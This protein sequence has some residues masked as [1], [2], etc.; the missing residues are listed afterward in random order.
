MGLVPTL[1]FVS[2]V[3]WSFVLGPIGALLA[4]PLTLFAKALL[5]DADP[6]AQWVRPLL[7]D[8]QEGGSEN[9][10]DDEAHGIGDATVKKV[11]PSP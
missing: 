10:G 2:L 3:F 8:R 5:I 6:S 11:A 7:G 4:V 1:T 9:S